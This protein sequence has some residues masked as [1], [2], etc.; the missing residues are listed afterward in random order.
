MSPSPEDEENV[1]ESLNL[2]LWN[3]AREKPDLI[4]KNEFGNK[5]IQRLKSRPVRA[6][7][8]LT[9]R[10]QKTKMGDNKTSTKQ[11]KYEKME[12]DSDSTELSPTTTPTTNVSAPTPSSSKTDPS[13][14]ATTNES[15]KVKYSIPTANKYAVLQ[16]IETEHMEDS[17]E[18]TTAAQKAVHQ[19]MPPI[20][21]TSKIGNFNQFNQQI[22]LVAGEDYKI[23]FL[24]TTINI[25]ALTKEAY[26]KIRNDLTQHK[27]EFYTFTP[28][29]EREKKIVLKA[30]PDL[31]MNSIKS[32]LQAK[33]IEVT[34]LIQMKSRK[35]GELSPSYLVYTPRT[36]KLQ[37]LRQVNR[38]ENIQTKWEYFAKPKRPTQC[39]NCQRLGHGSKN[40]NY[41]L[42]C[43]KCTDHHHTRDCKI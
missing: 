29:D 2:E 10:K 7:S 16:N 40:C 1:L 5:L 11:K 35:T 4:N 42:R 12:F 20:I 9:A 39:H 23:R 15:A 31:D 13:T 41:R 18:N 27:V 38:I 28:K 26:K 17:E 32:S 30:A 33:N 6:P 22:K 3:Y 14:T 34:N 43:V 25:T 19:K 36:T 37:E 8:Y 21:V 24:S